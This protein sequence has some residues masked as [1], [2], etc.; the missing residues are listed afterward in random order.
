MIIVSH[1]KRCHNDYYNDYYDGADGDADADADADADGDSD[2]GGGCVSN[3]YV[4]NTLDDLI[5][6]S[7]Y[8]MC[9]SF[10]GM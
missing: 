2:S 10:M 5:K 7:R 3:M 6:S 4:S 1:S 8:N 9:N